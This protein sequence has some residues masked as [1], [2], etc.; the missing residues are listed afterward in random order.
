MFTSDPAQEQSVTEVTFR[1][2]DS[3]YP[4]VGASETEECRFE[5]AEMI[6][7]QGGTYAEFFYVE[8]ADVNRIVARASEYETIDATKLSEHEAGGLVEFTVSG[9]CPAVTL[10]EHGALPKEVRSEHGQGRIVA[11]I[12][13]PYDASTVIERFLEENPDAELASKTDVDSVTP[14]LSTTSFEEA[15]RSHLTRRQR[16]VLQTAFQAGYYEWP[17]GSTGEQVAE[18]LGIASATF[19]EHIHAAE[20]NLLSLLFENYGEPAPEGDVDDGDRREY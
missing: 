14:V 15:V 16:E 8:D 17:R 1:I 20:R 7:R 6:P 13:P 10:A 11:E 12:P 3:T 18:D 19:S 2:R 9:N 5:L 4:F